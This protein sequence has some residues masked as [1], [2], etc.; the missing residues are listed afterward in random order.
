M[1]TFKYKRFKITK[2]LVNF[3]P[4]YTLIVKDYC[5]M[6]SKCEHHSGKTKF[7]VYCKHKTLDIKYNSFSESKFFDELN[8]ALD[9]ALQWQERKYLD[10][11]VGKGL[12]KYRAVK[13]PEY[14]DSWYYRK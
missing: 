1:E 11:L 13:N 2:K 3:N 9:F 7:Y 12:S 8:D 5:F 10:K 4:E 6:I 14:F